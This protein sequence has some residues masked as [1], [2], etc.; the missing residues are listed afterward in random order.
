MNVV[1]LTIGG[2]GATKG[3]DRQFAVE[4]DISVLDEIERLTFLAE[5]LE[6]LQKP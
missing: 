6:S 1:P 4:L 5:T 2:A 3:V